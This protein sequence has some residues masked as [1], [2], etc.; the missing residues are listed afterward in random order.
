LGIGGAVFL[1]IEMDNPFQGPLQI[2]RAP[3]ENALAQMS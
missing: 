2:P 1:I 3:M